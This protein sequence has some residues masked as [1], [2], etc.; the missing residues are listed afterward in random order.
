MKT[1]T[2]KT[3]TETETKKQ[4]KQEP[5]QQTASDSSRI[6]N[7][8]ILRKYGLSESVNPQILME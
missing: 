5:K 6:T 3:P 4:K 1:E 7:P 2:K 8:T